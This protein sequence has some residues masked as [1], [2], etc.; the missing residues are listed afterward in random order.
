MRLLTMKKLTT[1]LPKLCFMNAPP[2]SI[3]QT[4]TLF[5]LFWLYGLWDRKFNCRRDRVSST[6]GMWMDEGQDS[7]PDK[8]RCSEEAS[9]KRWRMGEVL[10][11]LATPCKPI[12]I[13]H[14]KQARWKIFKTVGIVFLG[15]RSVFTKFSA[16]RSICATCVGEEK[17]WMTLPSRQQLLF[18]LSLTT[19]L[20]LCRHCHFLFLRLA[21]LGCSLIEHHFVWSLIHQELV[22]SLFHEST[23]FIIVKQSHE[24]KSLSEEGLVNIRGLAISIPPYFDDMDSKLIP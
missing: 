2:F 20:L 10:I 1:W 8:R 18:F 6:V 3:Q 5:R 4:S 22:V 23:S 11:I 24:M 21:G 9:V 17:W 16:K 13:N 14:Q 7:F 12:R 15:A 19:K